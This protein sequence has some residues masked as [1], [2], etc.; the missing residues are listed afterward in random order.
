MVYSLTLK[1]LDTQTEQTTGLKHVFN[2][3][4]S[5]VSYRTTIT[6]VEQLTEPTFLYASGFRQVAK[7]SALELQLQYNF[8]VPSFL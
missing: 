7:R 3:V 2:Q 5:L 4:A 6:M 1:E 8:D